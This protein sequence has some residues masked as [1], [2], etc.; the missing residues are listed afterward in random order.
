MEKIEKQG[1][2]V[3]RGSLEDVDILTKAASEADAV[4]HLAYIHD[5]EAYGG[6]PA[7][8]QPHFYPSRSIFV[9]VDWMLT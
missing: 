8:G 9:F 7:Q 4:I 5:F 6:K 3:V 2:T 1:I